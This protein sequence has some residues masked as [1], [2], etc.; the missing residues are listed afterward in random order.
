MLTQTA[1][2]K[3]NA[4]KDINALTQHCKKK[5]YPPLVKNT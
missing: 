2:Y 3:L 5:P 1:L 4:F